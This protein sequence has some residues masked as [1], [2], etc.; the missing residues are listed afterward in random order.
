MIKKKGF[1]KNISQEMALVMKPSMKVKATG[2]CKFFKN[3]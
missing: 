1:I 2:V 3:E